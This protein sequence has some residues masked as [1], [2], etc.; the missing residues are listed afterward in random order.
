MVILC[1]TV[2]EPLEMKTSYLHK[3]Q[4]KALR[5]VLQISILRM[6]GR[7]SYKP[8]GAGGQNFSVIM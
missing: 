8:F 5:G 1:K 4:T 2:R 3:T 7:H 6:T